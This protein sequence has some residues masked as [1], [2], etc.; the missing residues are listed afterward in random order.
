VR[1]L[2]SDK[3][4]FGKLIIDAT[5]YGDYVFAAGSSMLGLNG[6]IRVYRY[7]F[8]EP[9]GCPDEAEVFLDYIGS[10]A[11]DVLPN[12]LY[13]DEARHCVYAGCR[14]EWGKGGA[15]LRFD[16]PAPGT[17]ISTRRLAGIDAGRI[18][19]SPGPL[20]RRL[21]PSIEGFALSG[22]HLYVA[23]ARN[24]LYKLDLT[25]NEYVAFYP[26]SPSGIAHSRLIESTE[27]IIPLA[28]ASAVALPPSGNVLV[29]EFVSGRVT[30]LAE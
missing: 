23:D 30:I 28:N 1:L 4:S 13:A 27:G 25:T 11:T 10:M 8:G 17:A 29:Q 20:S 26:G 19:L 22:N 16:L 2:A 15:L 7:K 21:A 14:S 24:G 18:D 9:S 6:E 3:L 12:E 5:A